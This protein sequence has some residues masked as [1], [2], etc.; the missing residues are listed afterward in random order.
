MAFFV[1]ISIFRTRYE[2]P[3]LY[4]VSDQKDGHLSP[5]PK[6]CFS[7]FSLFQTAIIDIVLEALVTEGKVEE[8]LCE[9]SASELCFFT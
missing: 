1:Q 3:H 5:C 4:P 2:T 7:A 8:V 9:H 6:W